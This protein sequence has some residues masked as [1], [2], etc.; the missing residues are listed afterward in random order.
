M[1]SG[2]RHIPVWFELQWSGLAQAPKISGD[3]APDL[4]DFAV[5]RTL[6]RT[7]T[8]KSSDVAGDAQSSD[9]QSITRFGNSLASPTGNWPY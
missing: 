6:L 7:G 2:V 4:H 5:L 8:I 1:P 9:R 3:H